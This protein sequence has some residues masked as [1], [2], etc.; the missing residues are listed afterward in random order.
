MNRP[1]VH[2]RYTVGTREADVKNV[3]VDELTSSLS[4]LAM[5]KLK[6]DSLAWD[7]I[8]E[9]LIGAKTQEATAIKQ[10]INALVET[11]RLHLNAAV[12]CKFY[13]D[14]WKLKT[15]AQTVICLLHAAIEVKLREKEQ[16]LDNEILQMTSKVT[17]SS[18]PSD[19]NMQ[20]RVDQWLAAH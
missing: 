6:D 16:R 3:D 2:V 12:S 7:I 17:I 15:P 11:Y 20:K 9:I 18:T 10:W 4:A 8:D 14:F 13:S 19:S 1:V 5:T